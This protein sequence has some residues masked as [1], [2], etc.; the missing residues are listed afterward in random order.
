MR[1]SATLIRHKRFETEDGAI[2]EIKIWKLPYSTI[3]RP[4]WPRSI[5]FFTGEVE[6]ELSD[7]IMKRGRG[8]D[9][10]H[11]AA[12][13]FG[14]V[15]QFKSLKQLLLG[16]RAGCQIRNA[17]MDEVK[18]QVASMDAFLTHVLAVDMA[19]KLDEGD[20]A[21]QPASLSFASM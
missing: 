18:I 9:H 4:H 3:E 6:S 5:R 16:F 19:R 20:F 15:G 21:T 10:R 1:K 2:V 11:Y 14:E 7:M 8:V 13:E 17:V 12:G